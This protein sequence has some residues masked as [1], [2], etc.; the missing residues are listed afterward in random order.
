[1]IGKKILEASGNKWVI[2]VEIIKRILLKIIHQSAKG[3]F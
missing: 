3:N 2:V 1:M